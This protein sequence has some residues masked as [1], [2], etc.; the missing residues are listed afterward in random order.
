LIDLKFEA[1][2][3]AVEENEEYTLIGFSDDEFNVTQYLIIQ[4]AKEFDKQDKENGMDT[5]HIEVNSETKSCYGGIEKIQKNS[6]LIAFFIKEEYKKI[7]DINQI[8]INYHID[9]GAEVQLDKKLKKIFG[10]LIILNNS[11]KT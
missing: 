4:Y 11:E 8:V 6:G 1:N 2:C 10:E 3:V 7:L 5:Y 9:T